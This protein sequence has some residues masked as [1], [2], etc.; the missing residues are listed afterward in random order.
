MSHAAAEIKVGWILH[1]DGADR[2]VIG[3]KFS[4]PHEG[5]VDRRAHIWFAD[6]THAHGD[7]GQTVFRVMHA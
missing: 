2:E 1:I 7:E 5:E 3:L 6:G 4:P